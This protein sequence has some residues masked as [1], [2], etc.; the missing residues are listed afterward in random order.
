[1]RH[2]DQAAMA[3]TVSIPTALLLYWT[4]RTVDSAAVT[5][6]LL[7]DG[8]VPPDRPARAAAGHHPGNVP[9]FLSASTGGAPL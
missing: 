5:G 4:A 1:M 8:P 2:R 6:E 3:M 7:D 9:W